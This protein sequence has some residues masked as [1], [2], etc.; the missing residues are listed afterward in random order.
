MTDFPDF[1]PQGYRVIRELGRNAAGG[2]VVYLC[3]TIAEPIERVVI[4]Q[5]QFARGSGWSQFKEIEREMQV[6]KDLEHPGIPCYLGSIQTDDGYSIVQ[7]FKDAQALSIPRSF[8][9]DQIKQIVVSIL[10]ILVYLQDRIP[11]VIHRDIK[12]ENV[13]VDADLN[14]YLIDFGFA[15]IGGGEVAMSSV[16]AGTF[17][18]MAPEQLYN[19]GLTAATDLYGLGAM[20]IALLTQTKSTRMDALIDE[21]GKI[22]FQHLTPKL[23]I[24]FMEWLETIVAPRLSDRYPNAEAALT[25]LKPIY[26]VR[27]PSVEF[28]NTILQ[29]AATRLG[30]KI[31]KTITV[32][33]S[34]A[35][36]LLEGTWSIEPHPHDPPNARDRHH[37]WISFSSREV[38][39]N[40]VDCEITVDTSNLISQAVGSRSIVL[41]SNAVPDNHSILLEIKTAPLPVRLRKLPAEAIILF[42]LFTFGCGRSIDWNVWYGAGIGVSLGFLVAV[43]LA[44]F[45]FF[46]PADRLLAPLYLYTNIRQD[47]L[48]LLNSTPLAVR[49]ALLKIEANFVKIVERCIKNSLKIQSAYTKIE[50]RIYTGAIIGCLFGIWHGNLATGIISGTIGSTIGIFV[51][52]RSLPKYNRESHIPNYAFIGAIASGWISSYLMNLIYQISIQSSVGTLIGIIVGAQAGTIAT[53]LDRHY[54]RLP[55]DIRYSHIF[56]F[57]MFESTAIFGVNLGASWGRVSNIYVISAILGASSILF[58]MLFYLPSQYNKKIATYRQK[59]KHLMKL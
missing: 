11:V 39:G 38:K 37:K 45:W 21:D 12:P 15:R 14:V 35:D 51:H 59:E 4:K 40:R 24:R 20:S 29:F 56:L 9:P 57:I 36:T 10:E 58:Y 54:D 22:T 6:L 25:A 46:V 33:N 43:C 13:L 17:G 23:S 8:D 48:V 3:E 27:Y 47:L 41:R 7:E 42:L 30:E 19:K 28:S 44:A 50:N 16:A 31:T 55:K 26:V 2:R 49:K 18:F 53:L 52:N 34:T 32:T 1:S 5:F